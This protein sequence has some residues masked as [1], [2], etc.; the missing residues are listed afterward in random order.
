METRKE[1]ATHP[2]Y[3]RGQKLL[4]SSSVTLSHSVFLEVVNRLSARAQLV[5]VAC[6]CVYRVRKVCAAMGLRIN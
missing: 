3:G 5:K 2:F 6:M 1:N 4:E